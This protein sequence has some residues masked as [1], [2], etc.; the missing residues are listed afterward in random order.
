MRRFHDATADGHPELW[1]PPGATS[2][3]SHKMRLQYCS[4]MPILTAPARSRVSALVDCYASEVECV[5]HGDLNS[6]NVLVTKDGCRATVIDFEQ[7]HLGTRVFDV[8]YLLSEFFL[9][10][11]L[12]RRAFL[13]AAIVDFLQGYQ[14][15][16]SGDDE[17]FQRAV[18]IHLWPQLIY[19]FVGP[20][21]M[22]WT[23]DVN[24]STAAAACV[25]AESLL[26]ASDVDLLGIAS[27]L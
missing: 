23:G 16:Y 26:V 6:R 1:F 21:R 15:G 5:V 11:W 25:W 27:S 2:F 17:S 22:T 7:A 18:G 14:S 8:A 19:R 20:S 12:H 9:R 24:R 13:S 10:L 3:K 4:L